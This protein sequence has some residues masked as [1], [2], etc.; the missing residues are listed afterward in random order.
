MVSRPFFTILCLEGQPC[1]T[2]TPEPTFGDTMELIVEKNPDIPCLL[3]FICLDGVAALRFELDDIP[4]GADIQ[5]ATL[6]L[7]LTA[8]VGEDATIKIGPAT[9]EWTED[10]QGQPVC[11]TETVIETEV[12]LTPGE[13]SWEMTDLVK[14][15]QSNPAD[16]YGFCL[17]IEEDATRIFSS[18]EGP[19]DLQPRLEV[20]YK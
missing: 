7:S 3:T 10:S 11:M 19:S 9:E 8:G 18:R 5:Q 12:D 17:L 16:N 20:V 2:S 4:G 13:Y 15:W 1:P 14:S 6:F